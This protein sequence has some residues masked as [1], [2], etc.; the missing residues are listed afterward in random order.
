MIRKFFYPLKHFWTFIKRNKLFSAV[1]I[2]LFIISFVLD[3]VYAPWN[4]YMFMENNPFE[5]Y[6]QANAFGWNLLIVALT[7]ITS[8]LGFESEQNIPDLANVFLFTILVFLFF[9]V[10][11]ET[12]DMILK[13]YRSKLDKDDPSILNGILNNIYVYTSTLLSYFLSPLLIYLFNINDLSFFIFIII[14]AVILL[15]LPTLYYLFI[16]NICFCAVILV[17]CLLPS[18]IPVPIIQDILLMIILMAASTLVEG[19][20]D[21][22]MENFKSKYF[23]YRFFQRQNL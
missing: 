10:Q 18:F 1:I 21:R 9:A 14:N 17:L 13:R 8:L 6:S 7:N 19:F 4:E 11:K 15:M 20:A 12:V 2:I 3:K 22:H 16:Y 5:I 23:I